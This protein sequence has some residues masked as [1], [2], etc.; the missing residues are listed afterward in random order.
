MHFQNRKQRARRAACPQMH[1]TF[2][3]L[4]FTT[5]L[6]SS[7]YTAF[8]PALSC[9]GYDPSWKTCQNLCAYSFASL[10]RTARD[11]IIL[12]DC[13]LSRSCGLER[14]PWSTERCK[15][16]LGPS[17]CKH[18]ADGKKRKAGL[19]ANCFTTNSSVLTGSLCYCYAW[20]KD[21][22]YTNTANTTWCYKPGAS[23][24]HV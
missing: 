6:T 19:T 11:L 7:Y 5:I 8:D 18:R 12:A 16:N 3:F 23:W 13:V 15:H 9:S 1:H 10:F 24:T 20:T 21:L 2:H 4:K 22:L 17:M 14:F